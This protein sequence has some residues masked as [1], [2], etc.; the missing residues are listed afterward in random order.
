MSTLDPHV[1]TE[2]DREFD[3]WRDPR[4]ESDY[5]QYMIRRMQCLCLF[6]SCSSHGMLTCK[7]LETHGCVISTVATDDLVLKHQAT[8]THSIDLVFV[9]LP[10]IYTQKYFCCE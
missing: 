1:A 4:R 6:T 2:S 9:V 10:K 8:S 5:L 3:W 7:Q